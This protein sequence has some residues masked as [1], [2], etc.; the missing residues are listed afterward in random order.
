MATQI[1][2]KE[3][4]SDSTAYASIV[5]DV[6]ALW[7]WDSIDSTSTEGQTSFKKGDIRFI[8]KENSSFAPNAY[9]GND[10]LATIAG[11]SNNVANYRMVSVK[12]I[13]SDSIFAVAFVGGSGGATAIANATHLAVVT[14]TEGKNAVS[15]NA[16][17]VA[18]C[19]HVYNNSRC[20]TLVSADSTSA[21][22]EAL[23]QS[24]NRVT[25]GAKITTTTSPAS[26]FYS[27]CTC[28]D[29]RIVLAW[30]FANEKEWGKVIYNDK[31]YYC[32]HSVLIP[33]E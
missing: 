33:I 20:C 21:K 19:F 26:P 2:D 29:I 13:V 18:H 6:T 11:D 5:A 7:K 30:S 12:Y 10:T 15:K 32:A 14:I 23:G 24:S 25:T 1:I 28:D 16:E 17:T 27:A 9:I 31:P 8:I 22:D 3:Y 4:P